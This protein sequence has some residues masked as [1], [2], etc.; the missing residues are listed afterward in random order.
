M[1]KADTHADRLAGSTNFPGTSPTSE[2]PPP[3]E[4][5]QGPSWMD[6]PVPADVATVMVKPKPPHFYTMAEVAEMFGRKPRTIRHWIAQGHLKRTK[7][8]NAVFISE[9]EIDALAASAEAPAGGK[10]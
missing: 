5:V 6:G 3:A 8:G 2:R 1:A 10:T 7:V 4:G 9:H